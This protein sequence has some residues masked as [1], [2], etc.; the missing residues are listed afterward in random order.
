MSIANPQPNAVKLPTQLVDL[1]QSE[2]ALLISVTK[3]VN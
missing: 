1:S 3:A 2:N